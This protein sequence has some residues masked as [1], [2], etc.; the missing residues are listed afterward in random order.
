MSEDDATTLLSSFAQEG[1]WKKAPILEV[2]NL[3]LFKEE[4]TSKGS[5]QDLHFSIRISVNFYKITKNF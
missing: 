3:Q 1:V 4:M 5:R 2:D